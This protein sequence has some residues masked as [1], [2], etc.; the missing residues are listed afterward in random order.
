MPKWMIAAFAALACLF[1]AACASH[2]TKTTM[3]DVPPAVRSTIEKEAAGGKV[4]E[5]EKESKKGKT[6]YSADVTDK[7]GHMW[8][9]HVAED[10]RLI[11][12]D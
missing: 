11:S 5:V 12:K 8:D 4:T 1:L 6:V 9:V 10:G 2:E 7:S 3:T